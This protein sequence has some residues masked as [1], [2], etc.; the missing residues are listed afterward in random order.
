MIS[1]GAVYEEHLFRNANTDDQPIQRE[2][3]Y[4]PSVKGFDHLSD[5]EFDA[6]REVAELVWS[7]VI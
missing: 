4:L 1:E 6:Q 3:Y 2:I 5:E 7:G